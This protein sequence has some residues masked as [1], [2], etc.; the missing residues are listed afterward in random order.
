MSK[1]T[2]RRPTRLVGN[3]E[4]DR[5]EHPAFGCVVISRYSGSP[6]P[7]FASEIDHMG[8]INLVIKE[9]TLMRAYGS[10][11][12]LS[13]R[14][15]AEVRMSALQFAELITSVG[16]GEGTPCTITARPIGPI[17]RV[18]SIESLETQ[19][20][21]MKKQV[22]EYASRTLE[23]IANRIGE[24]EKLMEGGSVSKTQ[25]REIVSGLKAHLINLP[26]NIAHCVSTAEGAIER[27][28]AAA[29]ADIRLYAQQ[30]VGEQGPTAQLLTQSQEDPASD[31]LNNALSQQKPGGSNG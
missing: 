10:E 2:A 27:A 21:F 6:G 22:A 17:E 31:L 28:Q 25:L 18:P 29:K 5:Y 1:S 7:M 14:T 15:I 30:H 8:G 12:H 9:A 23:A 4:G 20:E 24:I 3:Y 26:S 16:K 11:S 13:G 19:G